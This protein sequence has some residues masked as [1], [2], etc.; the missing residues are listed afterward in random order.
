MAISETAKTNYQTK[1]DAK[2][3]GESERIASGIG[4]GA[5]TA[6]GLYRM[7][8]IG[9]VLAVIGGALL[10]RGATGHSPIYDALDLNTADD[11][12]T[13]KGGAGA[14]AAAK[15]HSREHS[16]RVE[17]H[18][19][20]HRPLA[21]IFDFWRNF[22]NLPKIM[23]N[24]ESVTVIDNKRSRWKAKAPL[25]TSVEWDAEIV[26]EQKNHFIAWRSIEGADVDNS[27][28]VRFDRA[29]GGETKITVII[30]YTPPAGAIGAAAASLFGENPEQQLEEDLQKFKQAM[31][32]GEAKAV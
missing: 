31:E 7:D 10:Y 16:N 30:N 11:S 26:D 9:A 13:N 5:L 21:E 27:G 3:V 12:A 25:G 24:L 2:N 1:K 20:I 15:H 6:Y 22:E 28:S 19:K 23:S 18:I 32:S 14:A 29:G 4:G 8:L 17:K